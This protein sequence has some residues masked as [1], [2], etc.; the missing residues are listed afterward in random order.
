[1]YTANIAIQ[2][3]IGRFSQYYTAKKFRNIAEE[4]F[5]HT[6]DVS[7]DAPD[8]HIHCTGYEAISS[9]FSGIPVPENEQEILMTHTHGIRI[10]E[11][12]QSAEITC[13]A[14]CFKTWPEED[15]KITAEY[16]CKRLDADMVLENGKWKFRHANLYYFISL[17][18]EKYDP[19]VNAVPCSDDWQT[20]LPPIQTGFTTAEDYVAIRQVQNRWCQNKRADG[21]AL[22]SA[23]SQ[24]SFHHPQFLQKTAVGP[25]AVTAALETLDRLEEENDK[26]FIDI[27]MTTSGVIEVAEDG[28]SAVG[29]WLVI[30]NQIIGP[31]FGQP[32]FYCPNHCR[33]GRFKQT[34][35]KENGQ[36]KILHFDLEYL[37]TL[38]ENT[39]DRESS[40]MTPINKK[41]DNWQRPPA[42]TGYTEKYYEDVL[43]IEQLI[44]HWTYSLRNR[45]F[46]K[47]YYEYYARERKDLVEEG[48]E[49]TGKMFGLTDSFS[50]EQ[51]KYAGLHSG[52]TPLVEISEDGQ[53]ATVD[54]LDYGFTSLG[55]KFGFTENPFYA[56]G[57]IARYEFQCVKCDGRW[58]M[59]RM[60]WQPFYRIRYLAKFWRFDYRT[61]KGWTG[62]D[63]P[64]RFPL[65]FQPYTYVEARRD[66]EKPFE[67]EPPE[68]STPFEKQVGLVIGD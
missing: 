56:N 18:P 37:L 59:Y 46:A 6:S 27:P 40:R 23:D 13:M 22:F 34:F 50:F 28:Q 48:F 16:G 24:V 57:S 9:Y 1:M 43:E 62:A 8:D 3:T 33:L 63:T 35:T 14:Y 17:V 58:K 66:W 41:G 38:P 45:S 30:T 61:T 21:M 2:N 20:V 4:L 11:D 49:Y 10:A 68:L 64:A 42:I 47:F 65:P 60:Q 15:R 31:A 25:E 5:S 39:F 12:L 52:T 44:C 67:L 7:F 26:K 53:F 51:P 29:T 55:E 36:W 32:E 19:S 54:W